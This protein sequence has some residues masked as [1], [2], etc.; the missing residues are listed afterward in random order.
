MN[1]LEGKF[2]RI[3]EKF[4]AIDGKFETIDDGFDNIDDKLS[5]I[6][7][8]KADKSDVRELVTAVDAYNQKADSYFQEML[9]LS[10]Q[11]SRHEK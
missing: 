10:H 11:V 6:R 2:V 1:T 3:D 8:S 4:E 7:D 9:M 5:E